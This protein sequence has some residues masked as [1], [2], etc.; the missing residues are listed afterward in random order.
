MLAA[1][2]AGRMPGPQ[3]QRGQVKM[4]LAPDV[5][6]H[7]QAGASLGFSC[8]PD[9]SVIEGFEPGWSDGA[10]PPAGY[11]PWNVLEVGNGDT[12]G[13]YWPLGMEDRPP[14][15]CTLLHD[16]GMLLPIASG[17]PQSI[18]MLLLSGLCDLDEVDEV[19]SNFGVAI[20][21]LPVREEDQDNDEDDEGETRDDGKG[22]EFWGVP[23]ANEL[24]K[25]D[26]ESPHVR[27]L[28]ARQAI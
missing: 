11:L 1:T 4:K 23:T 9:G 15:V 10:Y 20:D 2:R 12:Y 14:I 19:A 5:S 16:A 8:E 13:F 6:K 18:R 22:I 21:D 24:L 17:F 3:S 26:P 7:L 25:H 28:A 27:L